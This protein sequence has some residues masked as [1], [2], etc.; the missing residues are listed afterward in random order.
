LTKTTAV[1]KLLPV[2]SPRYV[3]AKLER[4]RVDLTI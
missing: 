1:D 2:L 4:M 3:I